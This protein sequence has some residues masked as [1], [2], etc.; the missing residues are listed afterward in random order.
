MN[1]EVQQLDYRK[2]YKPPF[3]CPLCCRFAHLIERRFESDLDGEGIVLR[4]KCS[5]CGIQEEKCW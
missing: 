2:N 3:N 5:L 4:W 1:R